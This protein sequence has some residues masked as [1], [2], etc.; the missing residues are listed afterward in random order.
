MVNPSFK[1]FVLK[2]GIPLESSVVK[3]IQNI[4]FN[5]EGEVHYNRENKLFSTDIYA[6]K[7]LILID[8][9]ELSIQLVIECKYK[10]KNHS[11][12]FIRFPEEPSGF[13]NFSGGNLILS[14]FESP[15]LSLLD[16]KKKDDNL[17]LKLLQKNILSCPE[18]NKGIEIFEKG[19]NPNSIIRA[20]FQTVCGSIVTH[21]L[22][23]D[24]CLF[25]VLYLLKYKQP[26]FS[27]LLSTLTLPI[28][29][30]TADLYTLKENITLEEIEKEND[31]LKLCNNQEAVAVYNVGFEYF[32]KFNDELNKTGPLKLN[33]E[34][35]KLLLEIDSNKKLSSILS[36]LNYIHPGFIYII[37]YK[38]L[39]R[40]LNIL[41]REI[42]LFAEKYRNNFLLF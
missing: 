33:N 6:D 40:Q 5:D 39:D 30:T 7:N 37:N 31:T 29:V 20:I 16:K 15:V 14:E 13:R 17:N 35:S 25:D 36:R 38:Y 26:K 2:S 34:E 4:G 1:E 24:L 41:N 10:T 9:L 21:R 12:F 22:Y 23:R 11:W 19:A 18:V 3:K 27:T 32:N 28:I 42:D 8:R